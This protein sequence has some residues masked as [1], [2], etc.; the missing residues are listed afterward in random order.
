M[1]ASPSELPEL[2]FPTTEIPVVRNMS[3]ERFRSQHLRSRR[4]V[5]LRGAIDGWPAREWTPELLSERFGD[6]EVPTYLF[7]E[8]RFETDPKTGLVESSV[9][10]GEFLDGAANGAP[11]SHYVRWPIR[12]RSGA[13]ADDLPVPP[14][15]G[16]AMR[17][18]RN[19]WISSPGQLT[20]LHM[21]LPH[22]LLAQIYGTKRVVLFSP[23]ESRRLYRY[24]I[25]RALPHLSRVDVER[26]DLVAF[27]R[28]AKAHGHHAVI[29]PGDMLYIPPRW[30]HY[31]RS[32]GLS[33][34]V[35]TWWS[36]VRMYPM[37]AASDAYKRARGLRI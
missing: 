16:R 35:N 19:V 18:K 33:I 12:G 14:V 1:S 23:A 24:P 6:L 15:C 30:W 25:H 21:D 3:V 28:F 31:V 4:P 17:L 36:G 11:I 9:N 37:L 34:T 26:P 8:G 22:N 20:H 10:L 7:D 27:P 29:Q 2:A 13:L 5:V 32:L